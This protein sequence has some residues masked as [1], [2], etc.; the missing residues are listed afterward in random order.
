MNL[1]E[2]SR[3]K[4]EKDAII[5]A[6]YYVDKDIQEIA[7]YI[8]D[9][10]YLAKKATELKESTII[11][12]GVYFMGES[13]KILNPDKKVLMPDI[14]ADCP[15]AHMIS[16]EEIKKTKEK[17]DDIA[18]V[19][20]INSTAEIKAY[21]DV[22]VTSSNALKIVNNLPEKNIFFIPDRNLGNYIKEQLPEKNIIL[23][24]GYCPVHEKIDYN[25]LKN[26]KDNIK[27]LA[28]PECRKEVLEVADYI[29]STSNIIEEAKKYDEMIIATE[30][31]IFTELEKR[32]P[33]KKFYKLKDETICH[34]MKK[35]SVEKII[36]VLKNGGNEVFVSDDIRIKALKPLERMLEMGNL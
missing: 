6:H 27:V 8:G 30:E 36:N 12:A 28:H 25:Y 15:M 29:G 23:N 31:G 9:S 10:F 26:R 24:N 18:V 34:D 1:E 13:V 4:K 3:L 32:Y 19:T 33:N 20:Y 35:Q 17:Y 5:L 11:M 14:L 22:C 21:S 7:D 16:V 2:L